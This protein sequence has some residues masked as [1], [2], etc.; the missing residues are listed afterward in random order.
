MSN[1]YT[2]PK[3]GTYQISYSISVN[4]RPMPSNQCII[5]LNERDVVSLDL[6]KPKQLPL[7]DDEE[8]HQNVTITRIDK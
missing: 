1:T 6:F 4:S 5:H 7:F 3:T 2:V 8:T